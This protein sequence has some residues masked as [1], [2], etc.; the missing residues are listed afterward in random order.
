MPYHRF[1][2]YLDLHAQYKAANAGTQ[3]PAALHYRSRVA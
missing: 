1:T 3:D 2:A